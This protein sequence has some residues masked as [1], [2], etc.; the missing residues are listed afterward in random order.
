MSNRNRGILLYFALIVG[1]VISFTI[2]DPRL[3]AREVL[4]LRFRANYDLVAIPSYV[5]LCIRKY[6]VISG[7]P[8]KEI[9]YFPAS[10]F[11]QGA[12]WKD[13][14]VIINMPLWSQVR[15]PFIMGN[16]RSPEVGERKVI[17]HIW[18]PPY[19]RVD[20]HFLGWRT[21]TVFP[22]NSEFHPGW[23]FAVT[24]KNFFGYPCWENE[25]P[26]D[27]YHGISSG[28][29]TTFSGFG[30]INRS[31]RS[32]ILQNRLVD[33]PLHRPVKLGAIGFQSFSGQIDRVSTSSGGDNHLLQLAVIN[34]ESRETNHGEAD[35]APERSV[36]KP[37]NVFVK[38]VGAALVLIGVALAIISHGALLYLRW[39]GLGGL[40]SWRRLVIGIPG[41]LFAALLIW[42]GTSILL[43]I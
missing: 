7:P 34:Y 15:L 20:T 4:I 17:G 8:E 5:L 28:I 2:Q 30:S 33:C 29:R 37:V 13:H 14:G 27:R 22:M 18:H 1:T 16:A 23:G 43:D 10:D 41:W 42:H 35:L 3:N 40:G 21:P 36:L 6:I 39:I 38:L 19:V 11:G 9:L 25:S 24:T 26:L 31:F 32:S 12:Y